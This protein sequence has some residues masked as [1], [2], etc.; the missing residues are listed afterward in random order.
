MFLIKSD[1]KNGSCN[2]CN[3]GILNSTQDGLVYPYKVVYTF[4]RGEGEGISPRAC[5]NCMEELVK[6]YRE[7]E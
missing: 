3:K 4:S 2:F 5:H 6:K 1:L 7:I